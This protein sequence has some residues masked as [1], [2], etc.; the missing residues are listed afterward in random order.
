[1]SKSAAYTAAVNQAIIADTSGGSF[2]ITLPATPSVGDT[3]IIADGADFSINSLI[4]S[5]NGKLIEGY[6]TFT[7]NIKNVK[8]DFVYDGTSWQVFPTIS[9]GV[10]GSTSTS[11]AGFE[12]TF[13]LMGA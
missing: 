12:Q 7:L 10:G 13:L 6:N 8:V 5:G 1:M 2:T 4:V 11:A 9:A 3:V